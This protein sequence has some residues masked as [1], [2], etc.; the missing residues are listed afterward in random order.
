MDP[1]CIFCLIAAGDAQSAIVYEDK[2]LIAFLDKRPLFLGHCLVMPKK[3]VPTLYDLP[4]SLIKPLFTLTQ[5]VGKAV[6]NAMQAEGS[7]I[8][9]NNTVSQ[10]V[11]H[12]HVHIIPR[13]FKDG[14]RGF[15]WPRNDYNDEDHIRSIQTAI[16]QLISD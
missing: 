1:S 11:P 2:K 3:H 7:F 10:S 13:N 6:E 12:L 9:I 4:P 8:A 15:F 14:L 16:K 5:Q